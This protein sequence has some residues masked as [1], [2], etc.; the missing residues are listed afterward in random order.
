MCIWYR[1]LFFFLPFYFQIKTVDRSQCYPNLYTGEVCCICYNQILLPF[2]VPSRYLAA[3]WRMFSPPPPPLLLSLPL[4]PPPLART[5]MT[6][7]RSMRWSQVLVW[8]GWFT[9]KQMRQVQY[10]L[11]IQIDTMHSVYLNSLFRF[12][13][14]CSCCSNSVQYILLF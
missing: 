7:M 1:D 9:A 3:V 2:P 4:V 8:K 10:I 6:M 5:V 14:V 12:S 11:V 13:T